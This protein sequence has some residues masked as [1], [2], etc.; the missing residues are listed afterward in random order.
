MDIWK[1]ELVHI[2]WSSWRRFGIDPFSWNEISGDYRRGYFKSY[3]RAY[4]KSDYSSHLK[5]FRMPWITGNPEF[6]AKWESQT[7]WQTWRLSGTRSETQLTASLSALFSSIE[8]ENG[9][10]GVPGWNFPLRGLSYTTLAAT[11]IQ[12][13]TVLIMYIETLIAVLLLVVAVHM[14]AHS[15]LLVR[16]MVIRLLAKAP[17]RGCGKKFCAKRRLI[18]SC[19]MVKHLLYLFSWVLSTWQKTTFLV[20]DKFAI[21]L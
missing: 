16:S 18:N 20:L 15:N 14:A 8:C 1:L 4:R 21:C 7:S 5:F 10:W 17:L 11:Y 13:G 2:S 3:M 12:G 6:G 9:R 19:A